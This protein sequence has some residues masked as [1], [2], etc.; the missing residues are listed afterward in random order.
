MIQKIIPIVASI[1]LIGSSSPT[2]YAVD[3]LDKDY[4]VWT[5]VNKVDSKIEKNQKSASN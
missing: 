3:M 4:I 2:V 1:T 5:I